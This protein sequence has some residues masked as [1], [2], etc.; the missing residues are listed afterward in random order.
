MLVSMS[1]QI[2]KASLVKMYRF[3]VAYRYGIH[4]RSFWGVNLQV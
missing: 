4:K 3:E 2:I 1:K